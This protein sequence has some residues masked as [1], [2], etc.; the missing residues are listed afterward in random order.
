MAESKREDGRKIIFVAGLGMVGIAFI[1]KLLNLDETGRYHI[2]TCGEEV[3]V[4]YNRVAL[5]EYFQHRSIEKLYLNQPD[6]YASQSPE[7]FK[8]YT[9]ETVL[10]LNTDEHIVNTSNRTI[11]YD[12]CVLAT[13]SDATLPW[14]ADPKV[15]GV[16]VYRNI[17]DLEGLLAYASLEGKGKDGRVAVIGGGLLGLE[18][19]KA[20]YDLD[21]ISKVTIVN[22]RAFPLSRQLDTHGGEIVLRRI[23]AMGVQIL[24]NTSP[25]GLITAQQSGGDEVLKGLEMQDGSVLECDIVIFA[26]GIT[27]RDDL[28]RASNI[29]CMENGR[30]GIIVNDH[31]ETSAPDVFAIGECASWKGETYGLIGP[32]IEMADILAFNLTQTETSVGGFKKRQMNPPDLS[33]K[34]KLMGV[35]VASFGDFF[36]EQRASITPTAS[37]ALRMKKPAPA[38]SEPLSHNQQ[39]PNK[40]QEGKPEVWKLTEGVPSSDS[41]LLT[42]STPVLATSVD[43]SGIGSEAEKRATGGEEET[44]PTRKKHG[45]AAAADGLIETLT[46]RDPFA[47]VYKKFVSLALV[48]RL[49]RVG[50]DCAAGT[51]SARMESISLGG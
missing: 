29:Q 31:L 40:A 33:T 17:A 49:E 38:I 7:C 4:A 34:L 21:T 20:A 44:A 5:T 39:D 3:H 24:T 16:F 32:G 36:A 9:S 35:D 37:Q 22:R 8:F 15:Q 2:I 50:T 51:S 48:L 14:Y 41:P 46:Y 26:V 42:V 12:Y 25:S 11:K 43:G 1:E 28:A 18:A 27:P 10:S 30:H 45:A 6:W 19:A 23:E 13:G 47:G